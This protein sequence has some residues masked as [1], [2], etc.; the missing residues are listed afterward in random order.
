MNVE[1]AKG[2]R[3]DRSKW[4]EVISAGVS[5]SADRSIDQSAL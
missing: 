3:K 4:K 5:R 2:V 1:D